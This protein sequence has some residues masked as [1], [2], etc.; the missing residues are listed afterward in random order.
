MPKITTK[1]PSAESV[2][3]GSTATFRLPI[4]ATYEQLLLS[5]SGT[6]FDLSHMSEIRLVGNGK[7]IMRFATVGAKSGGQVLDMFNQYEG[8]AAAA[9]VLVLDLVRFNIRTRANEELTGLGTGYTPAM[10]GYKEMGGLGV[11][12]S[13]LY[14]EI[15]IKATASNPVLSAKAVQ[16]PKR[17][18][19]VI[20]KVRQFT[21]SAGGAGDYEISDLPRGDLINK[22]YIHSTNVNSLKIETDRNVRFERNKAENE[23]IQSDGVR[24][25]QTGLFVYDPSEIGNGSEA[26]PTRNVQDFRVVLDMAAAGQVP[27]TVEYIGAM[28]L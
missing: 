22:I 5:Y 10:A 21:Y 1:M 9:G 11:E 23:L 15:D 2:A 3:A 20:K 19:G 6:T 16:S 4:G 24:V 14:L 13:T 25:P 8:R 27:V 18:L 17:P 28:E 7:V 26:L 12:L